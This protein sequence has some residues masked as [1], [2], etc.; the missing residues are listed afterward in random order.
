MKFSH[1]IV[2]A[3]ANTYLYQYA[4]NLPDA[5]EFVAG[6]IMGLIQKDDL[7]NIQQCMT[8]GDTVEKEI[9]QAVSDIEKG[10]ISDIIA[11]VQIL[12]TLVQQLPADLQHC[13]GM[14]AD[15][16]RIEKWAEIFKNPTQLIQ[17]LTTNVIKNFGE[18][19]GDVSKIGTDFSGQKYEQAGVDVADILVATLGPVP[20]AQPEDLQ[21]TQWWTTKS[22]DDKHYLIWSNEFIWTQD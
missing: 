18:I 21:I 13:K 22:L 4:V 1:I 15:L 9:T 11:G 2:A 17:T 10:D 8:D 6:M 19:T 5:E 12:G 7:K 16:A 20:A 14:Q 3:T